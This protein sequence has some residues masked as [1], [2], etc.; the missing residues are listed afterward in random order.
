MW[1]YVFLYVYR[2]NFKRQ[3]H[4]TPKI[5]FFFFL[6][7]LYNMNGIRNVRICYWRCEC[8][9]DGTFTNNV[10]KIL[11]GEYKIGMI[12]FARND[13]LVFIVGTEAAN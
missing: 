4:P 1:F 2:Y 9:N 5:L 13:E 7:H 8:A 11:D 6:L 12:M 10:R 3:I